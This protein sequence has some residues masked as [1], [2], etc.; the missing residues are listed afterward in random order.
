MYDVFLQKILQ[1]DTILIFRHN[2]PDLDAL[3]AQIGLKNLILDN[4][5]GKKVYAL[6]DMNR[7]T[8]LGEMDEIDK[9]DIGSALAIILDVSEKRM[10]SDERYL[11]AKER[12]VIDHH[13][14]DCNFL[15]D[16]IIREESAAAT[17]QIIAKIAQ[18]FA[19][20]VSANVATALYSGI[21][22]DTGRFNY[23]LSE[24]LF[25]VS[26]F[27]I[28]N[29]ADAQKIYQFLYTEKISER[30]IRAEFTSKFICNPY[31]VAYM[32]NTKEDV[33]ASSLDV[34]TISR[35]MVSVMAGL[36][37]VEIW[38][39]FTYDIDSQNILCEFRSKKIP[40]VDIAKKYGGGGHLLAC[41]CCISNFQ[42]VEQIIEDFNQLLKK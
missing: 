33:L 18:N 32:V 16:L 29:G 36:E 26:A 15:T 22:T 24:E 19:W 12:I 7:F 40:I 20:K 9:I 27:L 30:K 4:F 1:Y 5:S 35:G 17:C 8:L 39:N 42:Q 28:K 14:N 38:A 31:G 23:S 13:K 34:F 25:L 10:V 37:E 6:G 3:G 41:G 11:Q 2:R 21:V